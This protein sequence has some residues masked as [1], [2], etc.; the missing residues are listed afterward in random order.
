MTTDTGTP[1][2]TGAPLPQAPESLAHKAADRAKI[3][4]RRFKALLFSLIALFIGLYDV[5]TAG[6][7][8][9]NNFLTPLLGKYVDVGRLL[10]TLSLAVI[11]AR[12]AMQ[13]KIFESANK[14]GLDN[15]DDHGA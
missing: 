4:A 10:A 9:L 7:I 2:I 12:F 11:I 6:G 14:N 3:V 15:P 13:N 5:V 1:A 8:D